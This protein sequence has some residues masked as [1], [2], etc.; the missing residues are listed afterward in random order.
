MKN[1]SVYDFTLK[2]WS[3]WLNE[4]NEPLYRAKQIFDWLYIKRI[5]TFDEMSNLTK[6]LRKKL[7]ENF[8]FQ[9]LIIEDKYTSESTIKYLFRLTDGHAIETVIMKHDY[10]TSICVSTQVG[11]KIGCTFCASSIGGLKRN[12][13]SGEIVSQVIEAQRILDKQEDKIKSVVIMGTGEPFD[14]YDETINFI[15]IIN[16]ENGINIGQRHITVSTSGIIPKI[17]EFADLNCQVVLAISLHAP[18]NEIRSK[19][20]PINNK[21][22]LNE[23]IEACNYYINITKRRVTFEYALIKDVN[24]QEKHAIELAE[25]LKDIKCHINLIPLNNS[26]GSE[27]VRS[28][29]NKISLFKRTLERYKINTTVRREHGNVIEAACGQLRAKNIN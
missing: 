21:Y 28:S 4:N 24:D 16:D 14:N 18:N 15:N 11:C 23:L 20:M 3:N 25:L 13:T 7:E 8:V 2:Q 29:N 9:T 26:P 27:Y 22:P 6:D 17:Y 5:N 1:K 19:I 10:G 12:L